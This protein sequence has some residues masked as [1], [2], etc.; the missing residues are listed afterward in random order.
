MIVCKRVYEEAL[1]D[2]GYRVLVDRLWPRGIRKT[3]LRLDEWNKA[4]S[5]STELRKAFH[6]ETL[7]FAE[8]SRQYRAE[9]SGHS[10][11]LDALAQRAHSGKVTLLYS[12]KNTQQNHARVLAE[13]LVE[14]NGKLL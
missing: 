13:V 7:D 6:S 14:S 5:P 4:L 3:D 11:H 2:D 10:D 9:L 12:A 8:F 1:P